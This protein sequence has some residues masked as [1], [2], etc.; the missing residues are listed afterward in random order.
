[1]A[2]WSWCIGEPIWFDAD[3]DHARLRTVRESRAAL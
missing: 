3:T 1:V 2:T